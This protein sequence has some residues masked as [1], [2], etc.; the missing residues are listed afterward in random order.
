MACGTARAQEPEVHRYSPSVWP[1]AGRIPATAPATLHPLPLFT[2]S[3]VALLTA[4]IH[5]KQHKK[6]FCS[7][8]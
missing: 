6:A 1:F 4:A 2:I 3:L 5:F 8:I 7:I